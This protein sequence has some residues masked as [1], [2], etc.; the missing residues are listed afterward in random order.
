M[1]RDMGQECVEGGR[2]ELLF[3]GL[4]LGTRPLQ[5]VTFPPLVASALFGQ[6]SDLL[7]PAEAVAR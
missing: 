2:S 6:I 1:D 5:Q 7:A 3:L 4:A